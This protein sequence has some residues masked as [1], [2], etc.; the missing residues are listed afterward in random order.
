MTATMPTSAPTVAILNTNDDLVELLRVA[1]EQAGF[2]AVSGH[3]DLRRGKLNLPDFLRQHD[4]KV[5]VY[6]IA[7]PYDRAVR[8][9]HSLRSAYVP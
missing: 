4:P 8:P 6:D 2:I 7:P 9:K 3:N 1:F 5:I